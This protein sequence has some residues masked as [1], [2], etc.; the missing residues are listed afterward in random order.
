[1]KIKSGNISLD[2]LLKECDELIKRTV[3]IK[4]YKKSIIFEK[5]KPAFIEVMLKKHLTFY[6]SKGILDDSKNTEDNFSFYSRSIFATE[7][8]Y[9]LL[10]LKNLS[11]FEKSYKEVKW[12][13]IE[14]DRDII[15]SI[16]IKDTKKLQFLLNSFASNSKSNFVYCWFSYQSPCIV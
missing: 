13:I 1:M 2:Q 9:Y 12:V 5:I 8:I 7:D 16:E 6:V 3:Q 10:F 15:K 11:D 4:N 14:A